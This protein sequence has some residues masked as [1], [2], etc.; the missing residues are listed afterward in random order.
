MYSRNQDEAGTSGMEKYKFIIMIVKYVKYMLIDVCTSMFSEDQQ[1]KT[2]IRHNGIDPDAATAS[3]TICL[4]LPTSHP[5]STMIFH[6]PNL[7]LN[8]FSLTYSRNLITS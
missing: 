4:R 8:S 6:N 2:E 3:D 7:I 5:C 1:T